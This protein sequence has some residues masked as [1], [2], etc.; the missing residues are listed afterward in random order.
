MNDEA[1]ERIA[2]FTELFGHAD[3]LEGGLIGAIE[4]MHRLS[5]MLLGDDPAKAGFDLMLQTALPGDASGAW[6]ERL[7]DLESLL[8]SDTPIGQLFH[9]LSAYAD[10]GVDL[11][12]GRTP[13]DREAELS[14]SI[15]TLQEFL[16]LLPV[17]TWGLES[18]GMMRVARKASVRWK[19]DND[20][21]INADELAILSGRAP[22]TIKNKLSGPYREIVGKQRR[23]E[24]AEAKAWLARQ[25]DFFPSIWREQE[26]SVATE[27]EFPEFEH[28]MFVPVAKDGTVFHPGLKRDGHYVIGGPGPEQQ[29]ADFGDALAKLHAMPWPEWRRPAEGGRWTKVRGVDWRRM[30]R[31]DLERLAE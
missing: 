16:A 2:Q 15:E 18:E 19:L 10:F 1:A 20:E 14:E 26:G 25:S 30:T 29:F 8:Y 31:E 9:D 27:I 21:P 11:G 17:S 22:Q 6:R 23:I 4:S 24:A 5:C 3:V 12:F 7:E 28:V 13:S